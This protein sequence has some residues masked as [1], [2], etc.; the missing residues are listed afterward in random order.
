MIYIVYDDAGMR[1]FLHANLRE[2]LAAARADSNTYLGAE[3]TVTLDSAEIALV[4]DGRV[5]W[6][7]PVSE[8]KR[9]AA[10]HRA[11]LAALGSG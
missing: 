7:R 9:E 11:E 2:A 4:R 3:R 1:R 5:I 8:A 6:R 10:A